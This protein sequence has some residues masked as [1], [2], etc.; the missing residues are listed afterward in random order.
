MRFIPNRDLRLLLSEEAVEHLVGHHEA[1]GVF[2]VHV[3]PDAVE[4]SVDPQI[5]LCG[6]TSLEVAEDPVK[7]LARDNPLHPFSAPAP[8]VLILPFKSGIIRIA[9]NFVT[10]AGVAGVGGFVR[11]CTDLGVVDLG[12]DHHGGVRRG[13][14]NVNILRK[15]GIMEAADSGLK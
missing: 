13:H 12:I 8:V 2:P 10:P 5:V 6:S 4:V 3:A 7:V 9:V 11:G 15:R 14:D 1:V